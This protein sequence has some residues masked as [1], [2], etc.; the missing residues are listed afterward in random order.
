MRLVGAVAPGWYPDPSGRWQVR[1]WDG[2]AWSD[3]VAAGGRRASD[4][5]PGG[6]ATADLVNRVVAAALSFV[7]LAATMPDSVSDTTI[8]PALWREATT[9]RDILVL[10]HGHLSALEQRGSDPNRAQAL[11]YIT[12]ALDNPPLMPR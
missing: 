6:E 3:H 11:A 10:A 2:A 4:P 1:W 5:A 7:D 12:R 9:R 8:V